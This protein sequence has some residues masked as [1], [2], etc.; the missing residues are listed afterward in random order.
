MSMTTA[1][2][3]VVAIVLVIA[4]AARRHRTPLD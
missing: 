1:G 3:V 4:I 2:A